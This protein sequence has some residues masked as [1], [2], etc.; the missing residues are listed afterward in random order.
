[1]KGLI[2]VMA[3]LARLH[4]LRRRRIADSLWPLCARRDHL[5]RHRAPRTIADL[6]RQP[7]I[8]FDAA[9]PGTGPRPGCVPARRAA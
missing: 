1:M 5:A 6:A 2:P 4:L 8:G 9:R 3:G 7:R